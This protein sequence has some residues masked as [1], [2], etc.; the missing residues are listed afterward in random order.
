MMAS[1][2]AHVHGLFLYVENHGKEL[3][4]R[5]DAQ[6]MLVGNEVSHSIIQWQRHFRFAV[7]HVLEIISTNL[8]MRCV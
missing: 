2:S 5:T 1:E 3:F 8:R 6:K 4:N 7:P